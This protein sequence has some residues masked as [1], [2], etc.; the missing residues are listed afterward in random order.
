MPAPITLDP[1]L[2]YGF[3]QFNPVQ[4]MGGGG[5]L[6]DML[7]QIFAQQLMGQQ[8]MFPGGMSGQNIYDRMQSYKL[9]QMHDSL[10]RDAA[11]KDSETLFQTMLGGYR[12]TGTPVGPEQVRNAQS[13]ADMLSQLGPTAVQMFPPDMLDALGGA[14]GLNVVMAEYMFRGSRHRIDPLTGRMGLGEGGLRRLNEDVFQSMFAGN[15]WTRHGLSAGDTGQLFHEM[16]LAGMM[17]GGPVAPADLLGAERPAFRRQYEGAISR[18]LQNIDPNINVSDSAAIRQGL[19]NLNPA[20]AAALQRDPEVSTAIKTFDSQRVSRTLEDYSGVIKSMREIFGDAGR[21]NAPIPE[22]INALNQLT[23]GALPQLTPGEVENMVRNT[24][25][26]A[27][28][29]GIGLEGAMMLSQVAVQ[30][31]QQ[32]GLP[33]IFASDALQGALAFRGAQ[34]GLGANVPAWGASGAQQQ[35]LADQQL[36]LSAAGSRIGNQL[37]TALRLQEIMGPG[38]FRPG[39]QAAAYLAAAQAGSPTFQFGGETFNIGRMDEED[40][41]SMIQQ[42]ATTRLD[43]GTIVDMMQQRPTNLEYVQKYGV[44]HTVR[45]A[46]RG[47]FFDFVAGATAFNAQERIAG[48]GLGISG[49]QARRLGAQTAAAAVDAMSNLKPGQRDLQTRN[50]IMARAVQERL[51]AGAAGQLAGVDAGDAQTLLTRFKDDVAFRRLFVSNIWGGA[52]DFTRDPSRNPFFDLGADTLQNALGLMDDRTLEFTE[53]QRARAQTQT[54]MQRAL[55]PLG[56]TGAL[57]RGIQALQGAGPDDDLIKLFSKGFGGIDE[58]DIA[59][60]LDASRGTAGTSVLEDLRAKGEAFRKQSELYETAEGGAARQAALK[61]LQEKFREYQDAARIAASIAR[62]KGLYFGTGLD[63]EDLAQMGAQQD[64]VDKMMADKNITDEQF[65]KAAAIE[66]KQSDDLLAQMHFDEESL[67]RLGDDAL[68]QLEKIQDARTTIDVL[69]TKFTGGDVGKLLRGNFRARGKKKILGR[70]RAARAVM[71][72]G[73]EFFEKRIGGGGEQYDYLT[74]EQ[75]ADLGGILKK[76]QSAEGGPDYLV[77]IGQML[78]DVDPDE[79]LK[80]G[81][82]DEEEANQLRAGQIADEAQREKVKRRQEDFSKSGREI[83]AERFAAAHGIKDVRTVED[84]QVAKRYGGEA[85]YKELLTKMR[86]ASASQ[87]AAFGEVLREG[88]LEEAALARSEAVKDG[89]LMKG[90]EAALDLFKKVKR[91]TEVEGED[92]EEELTIKIDIAR[93]V[94]DGEGMRI[95]G[96]GKPAQEAGRQ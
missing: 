47:E 80:E 42:G 60:A 93:V 51:E 8:S 61:P 45:M 35:M 68:V 96:K 89:A 65:G 49:D 44:A 33:P 20:Q 59:K 81:F 41:I 50:R 23:G 5:G 63:R 46:Q 30:Q 24:Y 14:R 39:S 19:I 87:R 21:P 57:R 4:G 32:M 43:E 37:G 72:A 88:G 10:L 91:T 6:M 56:R 25:N 9:Q 84:A 85:R 29:T 28:N 92:G 73:R 26:L 11:K 71:R 7:M 79:L 2:R 70:V 69:A 17:P 27:R 94:R 53:R 3:T 78:A 54:M 86:G 34:Q 31:A 77:D 52:E 55:S 16:Q 90:S 13:M 83:L 75:K 58:A 66:L 62:Q 82:I 15:N 74:D 76:L 12:M 48:A 67:M 1:S 95:E 40:F 22:L 38:G 36:R 18:A 64:L